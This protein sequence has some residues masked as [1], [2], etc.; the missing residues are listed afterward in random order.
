MM[1]SKI[2]ALTTLGLA[3]SLLAADRP[4][5]PSTPPRPDAAKLVGTWRV[6]LRSKPGDAPYFQ[7]FI[8]A[9]VDGNT[10][11]GTFYQSEVA[12]GRIN[13][14]W[15]TVHFAFTTADSQG[16]GTYNTAGRLVGDRL[17]GTTH[18][19]GRKFLAV[20][21]AERKAGKN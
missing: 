12:D 15:G 13:T 8:V 17:E 3:T 4:D 1:L 10:L 11:A 18:S 19:L 16:R 21:T 5:E 7:D 20:W 2:F 14:D 6:D 9:K